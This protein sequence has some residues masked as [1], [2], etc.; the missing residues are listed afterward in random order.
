MKEQKNIGS[1]L[2]KSPISSKI[3]GHFSLKFSP[4]IAWIILLKCLAIVASKL[5]WPRLSVLHV[6]PTRMLKSLTS[7]SAMCLFDREFWIDLKSDFTM[8]SLIRYKQ[9][10][11]GGTCL[12]VNDGTTLLASKSHRTKDRLVGGLSELLSDG[13]YTYQDFGQRFTLKGKVTM[14][15][16]ITSEAFQNYK[17]RLFGLTFSERFLIVHYVLTKLEKEEWVAKEEEM[18]K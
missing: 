1:K 3:V 8:N 14:V 10:L 7:K 9:E 4:Q 12:F 18:K 2:D 16:N 6:A 11:E 15:L 13:S 17:D 5:D